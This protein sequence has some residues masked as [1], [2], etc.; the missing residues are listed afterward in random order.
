[1]KDKIRKNFEGEGIGKV[2]L[3]G[4]NPVVRVIASFIIGTTKK[5]GFRFFKSN[6]EALAWLKE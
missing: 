2:A 5:E 3:V 6:D 4:M 1:M